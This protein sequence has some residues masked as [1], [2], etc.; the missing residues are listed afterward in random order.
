MLAA[1]VALVAIPGSALADLYLWKDPA[2]GATR[3]YSYPPPWYGNPDLEKRSPKVE[4]IP[5]RQRAP[6][7]EPAAAPAAQAMVESKP[8]PAV[9]GAPPPPPGM[10]GPAGGLV[11]SL[12]APLEAQ[13]KR[14]LELFSSLPS[15]SDFDRAGQGLQQ[16]LEAYE[17]VAAELDRIDPKGAEARRADS[18]TLIERLRD[19]VRAQAGASPAR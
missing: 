3:I 1:A 19:G 16:Q 6:A 5:S 4:R 2:T 17:A 12:L 9:P 14:L 15:K 10:G 11:S 18:R 8:A 7:A 13:R